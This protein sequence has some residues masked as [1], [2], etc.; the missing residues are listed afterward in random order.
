MVI[1]NVDLEKCR[2]CGQCVD[3]CSLE[4]W[5]LV[6]VEGGKKKARVIEEAKEICHCCLA[7]R[8]ICPEDAITVIEKE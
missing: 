4:L 1:H 3:I 2:G 7:C 5:E 6:D 8:D